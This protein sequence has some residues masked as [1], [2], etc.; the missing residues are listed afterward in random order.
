MEPPLPLS[1]KHL[2]HEK[3]KV[4]EALTPINVRHVVRGQYHGYT[5][6]PGV[7]ADSDTETMVALRVFSNKDSFATANALEDYERLILLA[8][9]GDQS[10]FTRSDGIER[11]W[12]ISTTIRWARRA[13]RCRGS[14]AP[15]SGRAP[16]T[17][18][19]GGRP[20]RSV[21]VIAHAGA[22]MSLWSEGSLSNPPEFP[23][24]LRSGISGTGL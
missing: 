10:L 12:E 21:L 15:W 23:G 9:I 20:G 1:A 18:R 4:Y 14:R 13:M 6:E 24:G 5:S 17:G 2:R 11:L 8:M 3:E 7:P 19:R 22:G 16:A